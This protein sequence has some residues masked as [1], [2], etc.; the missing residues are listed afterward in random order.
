M[1]RWT[2]INQ[3]NYDF[4]A[5]EKE[6]TEPKVLPHMKKSHVM[7]NGEWVTLYNGKKVE[8]FTVEDT[9]AFYIDTDLLA[10]GKV[11]PDLEEAI[12]KAGYQYSFEGVKI[13]VT[14]IKQANISNPETKTYLNLPHL[15]NDDFKKLV[16]ELKEN[17]AQFDKK[18]KRWYVTQDVELSKFDKYI[19]SLTSNAK[20]EEHELSIEEEKKRIAK[21]IN[22]NP[23]YKANRPLVENIFALN[24]LVGKEHTVLDLSKAYKAGTYKDN[25]E[26]D[27]LMK[28]IGK[29]F[30]RQEQTRAI[31]Q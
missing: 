10:H 17:G 6:L 8:E 9:I 28:D 1:S 23:K 14:P 21:A 19:G 5:L 2:K 4:E 18:V 26:A 20:P 3:Q 22:Q 16:S 29:E 15:N 25:P 11:M 13:N 30:I 12:K 31:A 27:K 24:K 7:E